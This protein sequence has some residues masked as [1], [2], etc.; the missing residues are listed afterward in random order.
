MELNRMLIDWPAKM[1]QI[2]KNLGLNQAEFAQ[3]IGTSQVYIS[4][5]ESGIKKPGRELLESLMVSGVDPALLFSEKISLSYF[6]R[7]ESSTAPE[8]NSYKIPILAYA[9]CGSQGPHAE[10]SDEYLEIPVN[11]YEAKQGELFALKAKGSSMSPEIQADD[12]IILKKVN[13]LYNRKIMA[14]TYDNEPMIKKI[15]ISNQ[16]INLISLNYAEFPPIPVQAPES[17]LA[18]GMALG[19]IRKY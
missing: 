2:R 18:H 12:F 6:G 1:R 4:Q 14:I 16:I 7:K 5:L 3:K 19:I 11:F 13:E 8:P 9:Q 10:I 15:E 17:I